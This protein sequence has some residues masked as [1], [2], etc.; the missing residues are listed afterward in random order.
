MPTATQ[1][2]TSTDL[3]QVARLRVAVM[4][5]ARRMRQQASG[6]ITPSQLAVLGNLERQGALTL[7]ELA[8]AEAIQPPSI[9]RVV[10]VLEEQGLV[11]RAESMEDRR[12]TRV[13]LTS[14]A[15]RLVQ[16]IRNQRTAWLAERVAELPAGVRSEL[17]AGVRA[18]EL[19]LEHRS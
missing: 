14:R 7:G 12:V 17:E 9:T 2:L 10:K 11:V 1:T 19:I 4:R 18:I 15:R 5:L 16:S 13:E 3:E 6:N 8:L